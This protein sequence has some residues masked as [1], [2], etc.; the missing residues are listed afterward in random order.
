[1]N[2]E[3]LDRYLD[4]QDRDHEAYQEY[5]NKYYYGNWEEYWKQKDAEYLSTLTQECPRC[6]A[7]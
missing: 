6:K 5:F 2:S 7:F 3:P 4:Q 1:M